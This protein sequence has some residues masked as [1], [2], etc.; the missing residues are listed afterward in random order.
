MVTHPTAISYR[1][2]PASKKLHGGPASCFSPLASC[3]VSLLT[4]FVVRILTLRQMLRTY[5][6]LV[7]LLKYCVTYILTLLTSQFD[8]LL[9]DI[10]NKMLAI[11]VLNYLLTQCTP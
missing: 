5:L 6:L 10:L 7:Y 11:I 1:H 4:C 9:T 8:S 3:V 2:S